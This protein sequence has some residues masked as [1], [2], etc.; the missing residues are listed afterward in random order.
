MSR[1]LKLTV[2]Y[3]HKLATTTQTHYITFHMHVE[4]GFLYHA[5]Q[6]SYP[7]STG[8][9]FSLYTTGGTF[10]RPTAVSA[11]R[12]SPLV[13]LPSLEPIRYYGHTVSARLTLSTLYRR[14]IARCLACCSCREAVRCGGFEQRRARQEKRCR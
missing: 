1:F 13:A 5:S 12:M 2:T 10:S 4:L 3:R 6:I 11:C 9:S 8:G 7:T 14:V